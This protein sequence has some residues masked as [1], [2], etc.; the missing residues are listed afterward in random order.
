MHFPFGRGTITLD[1]VLLPLIPF[2][3]A[4]LKTGGNKKLGHDRH[5]T[6]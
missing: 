5:W 1:I 3:V 2:P 6:R 4:E